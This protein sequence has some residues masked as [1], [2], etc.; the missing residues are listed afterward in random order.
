MAVTIS[1]WRVDI[2]E[3]LNW[4]VLLL[5]YNLEF[6]LNIF[7]IVWIGRLSITIVGIMLFL[8][9]LFFFGRVPYGMSIVSGLIANF[10]GL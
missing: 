6:L 7:A 4:L 3:A 9:W 10:S 2:F 8:F 1:F 5:V